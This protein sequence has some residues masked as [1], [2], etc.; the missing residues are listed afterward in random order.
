ML[1]SV[2]SLNSFY[3]YDP[4]S[5]RGWLPSVTHRLTKTTKEIYHFYLLFQEIY[6]ESLEYVILCQEQ[7]ETQTQKFQGKLNPT[8]LTTLFKH[9]LS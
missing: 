9:L 8:L 5:I 1:L 4:A 7:L 6:T 3:P 2:T